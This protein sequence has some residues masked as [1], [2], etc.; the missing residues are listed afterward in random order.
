MNGKIHGQK[1]LYPSMWIILCLII[2][3]AVVGCVQQGNPIPNTQTKIT[4]MP[5]GTYVPTSTIV[6]TVKPSVTLT[7][8]KYRTAS[9]TTSPRPTKIPTLKPLPTLTTQEALLKVEDLFLHNGGCELPCWWGITP[10]ETT[11]QSTQQFLASF[12]HYVSPF[13]PSSDRGYEALFGVP[14]QVYPGPLR[15]IYK[16]GIR[17]NP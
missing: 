3:L 4:Q 7:P 12:A 5:T 13:D 1:R 11:W 2:T 16:I 10:G 17:Q 9:Q 6:H 8:T 15:Q 14:K